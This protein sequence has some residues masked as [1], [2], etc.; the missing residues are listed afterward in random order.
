ML[1]VMDIDESIY[2]SGSPTKEKDLPTYL[3]LWKIP[4]SLKRYENT[5][6]LGDRRDFGKYFCI[7]V[8]L[9][10]RFN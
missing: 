3:N 8:V 10:F 9:K 7:S 6:P 5:N 2:I 1:M 4:N